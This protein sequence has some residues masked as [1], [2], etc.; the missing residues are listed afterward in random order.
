MAWIQA[1]KVQVVETPRQ[2][3]RVVVVQAFVKGGPR[4]TEYYAAWRL[5]GS[6]LLDGTDVYTRLDLMRYG[7]RAGIAPRVDVYPDFMTVTLVAPEGGLDLA[8][9]LMESLLKEPTLEQERFLQLAQALAHSEPSPWQAALAPYSRPFGSVKHRDVLDAYA[10][11]FRPENVVISVGGRFEPGAAARTFGER[12]A[13]WT[14][15]RKPP[16]F[17][18]GVTS[19]P[20]SALTTEAAAYDF[21]GPPFTSADSMA[22]SLLA[23]VA[24]GVGRGSAMHRVLREREAISYAQE[25]ML[26]PTADGPRPRLLLLHAPSNADPELPAKVIAWLR[27]DVER[28]QE[29]DRDRA[30]AVTEAVLNRPDGWQPIPL[31][32]SSIG[33]RRLALQVCWRGYAAMFGWG[34]NELGS[35]LEDLRH[36][37]VTDL[38]ASAKEILDQLVPRMV[39]GR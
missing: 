6:M 25:A 29:S 32:V 7:S 1:S 21:L 8:A 9:S 36:V 26:W 19:K 12:M 15:G 28:W 11:A 33:D 17:G 13:T 27:A 16:R 22:R 35:L 14:P 3:A 39:P 10:W 24:L 38:Q 34:G 31:P 18:S 30:L 4:A 20:L 5:L 2:D 37:N 23:V